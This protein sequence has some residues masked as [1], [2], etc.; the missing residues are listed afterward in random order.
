M[1][2]FSAN[3]KKKLAQN[4]K[5]IE[6]KM[7]FNKAVFSGSFLWTWKRLF[8]KMHLKFFLQRPKKN[9][10]HSPEKII[11]RLIFVNHL[12]FSQKF[13]STRKMQLW[14]PCRTF[15]AKNQHIFA[16]C[17]TIFIKSFIFEKKIFSFKISV[18]TQKMLSQKMGAKIL[19]KSDNCRFKVRQWSSKE[20]SFRNNSISPTKVLPDKKKAVLKTMPKKFPFKKTKVFARKPEKNTISHCF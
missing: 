6:N 17:L 5:F 9:S 19:R 10:T 14:Q 3:M 2:N 12:I 13:S 15:F 8:W 16:Q 4:F 18:W 1:W 20:V 11:R 7:V